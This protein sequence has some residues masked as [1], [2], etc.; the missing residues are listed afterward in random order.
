[1]KLLRELV[2]MDYTRQDAAYD[3][4][5]DMSQGAI[6]QVIENMYTPVDVAIEDLGMDPQIETRML[7]AL[8][9]KFGVADAGELYINKSQWAEAAENAM[10]MAEARKFKSLFSMISS[11]VETK[12]DIKDSD[13]VQDVMYDERDR[14]DEQRDPY[15][16]RGVGKSDFY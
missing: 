7:E 3:R 5:D 1:M 6:D 14:E 10:N 11:V 8:K 4:E 16:Y 15:G 13:A 12:E 9:K 2:E